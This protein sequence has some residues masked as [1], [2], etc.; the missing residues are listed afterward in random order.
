MREHKGS[1]QGHK[2]AAGHF[3]TYIN[4]CLTA[5]NSPQLGFFIGPIC[6]SV[7]CFADDTY[8]LSDNPRNLQSLINIIRHYG[9]RYRLIFGAD[10]TKVT[11]TGSNHDMQYYEDINIWSLYGEK[12]TVAEDNDH[13]GLIVSGINEEI[14]NVDKNIRST[15]N[16]LFGF[17]GNIFSYKCKL[18]QTV[19][20]HTWNVFIKPVLRSG[21]AALP[22]RPQV[23]KTIST[24][25]HK[26]L[27]AMLKLSHYS[28][29]APLYFLLGE[30]PLEASLHLDVL[31]L[32]W[33]V[34]TNP[35]TKAYEVVKY[36]LKLSD[37]NS[38]TWSAHVT[39]IFLVYELPDP[40]LLLDSP[41]WTKDRWKEHT[42]IA[43]TSHHEATLRQKAKHN[44]KL[45]F[46]NVQAQGLSGRPHPILSWVMT[47]RDVTIIRPHI[48][49][50]SG[51]Y[52]CY[53][54]LYHDRGID[55]HCRMCQL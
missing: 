23:A 27:R 41:P 25:H 1:R 18:S 39:T 50:L 45:N 16:A 55:P 6:I 22:I 54:Y 5:A 33:N 12:L 47:T 35:Q 46:L 51:D 13:L 52:L 4:P 10:T 26:V 49:M 44:Y 38:L 8:V 7:I 11:I 30:L 37:N 40:L 17:L 2:R 9:R 53:S 31:S 19:Q 14:K 28:P 21:L 43:V 29:V 34:W 36:I 15:K 3:K 32:F 24:F 48:K 42:K 20:Y